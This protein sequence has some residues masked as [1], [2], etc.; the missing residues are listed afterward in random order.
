MAKKLTVGKAKK[1]LAPKR[2][3]K[4]IKVTN[5]EGVETTYWIEVDSRFVESKKADLA[6]EMILNLVYEND[7]QEYKFTLEEKEMHFEAYILALCLKH[8]TTLDIDGT[9]EEM[10]MTVMDF[11]DAGIWTDVVKTMDEDQVGD[12][13]A[14][15]EQFISKNNENIQIA[16][17]KA[18]QEIANDEVLA[19]FDF[20]NEEV[21]KDESESE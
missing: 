18:K 4:F 17:E 10:I 14:Y 12:V 2:E 7:E 5:E 9:Y 21:D 13:I 20:V 15:V 11:V 8:F 6:S 16:I 19:Q 3:K 1:D